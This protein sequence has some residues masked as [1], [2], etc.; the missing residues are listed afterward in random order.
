[1]HY[2]RKGCQKT[3]GTRKRMCLIEYV[4][5][6]GRYTSHEEEHE[7]FYK[8]P[9]RHNHEHDF[10]PVMLATTYFCI[11]GNSSFERVS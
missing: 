9:R 4:R 11:N 1:M 3:K 2:H 10:C 6:K 5:I 8:H 7:A